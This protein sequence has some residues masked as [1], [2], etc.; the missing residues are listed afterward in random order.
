MAPRRLKLV[1]GLNL[2]DQFKIPNNREARSKA[3]KGP[4]QSTVS[5]AAAGVTQSPCQQVVS[6]GCVPI[7]DPC[8]ERNRVFRS[9]DACERQTA[10]ASHKGQLMPY[11]PI[12]IK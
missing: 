5:I 8:A 2:A 7:E 4:S 10:Q 11:K 9:K 1:R 3:L 12:S 6:A